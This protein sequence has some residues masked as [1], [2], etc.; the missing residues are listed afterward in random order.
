V[1]L[2]EDYGPLREALKEEFGKNPRL[3][4]VRGFENFESSQAELGKLDANVV[5][6]D[7]KLPGISG[8][9]AT[10]VL[11]KKWPRLR[12]LIFSSLDDGA[13]MLEALKAGADGFVLKQEPPEKL[14]AAIERVHEGGSP[15]SVQVADE[16]VSFLHQLQPLFQSLSPMEKQVLSELERGLSKKEAAAKLGISVNTLKTHARAIATKTGAA[17]AMQA[18]YLRRNSI[19]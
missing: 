1:V 19:F 10:K 17:S 4:F 8:V 6:L 2:I 7:L 12:V 15:I 16:L 13:V 14:A 18:V 3:K 9:E 5:L 11:K